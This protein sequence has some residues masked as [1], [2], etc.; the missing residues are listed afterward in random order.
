MAT[1]SGGRQGPYDLLSL[2]SLP[3]V[4]AYKVRWCKRIRRDLNLTSD[5]KADAL[6]TFMCA[7]IRIAGH[8]SFVNPEEEFNAVEKGTREV[9]EKILQGMANELAN[10][11]EG[12][13]PN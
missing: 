2:E 1:Y 6:Y 7:R 5:D 4:G 3:R 9:L 11:L 13:L 10:G 8:P 12:E